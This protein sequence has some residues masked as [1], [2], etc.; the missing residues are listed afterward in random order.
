MA[1]TVSTLI[2]ALNF[3]VGNLKCVYLTKSKIIFNSILDGLRFISVSK[4]FAKKS[5]LRTTAG[6]ILFQP[7][8]FYSE[9]HLL[10]LDCWVGPL[11]WEARFIFIIIQQQRFFFPVFFKCS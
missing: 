8:S 3:A 5:R 4:F 6:T 2:L 10:L 9:R 1:E 11:D 7:H